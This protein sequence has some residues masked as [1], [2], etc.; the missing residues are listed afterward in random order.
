MTIKSATIYFQVIRVIL[1]FIILLSIAPQNLYAISIPSAPTVTSPGTS[2]SPGSIISEL[3]PILYWN[4]VLGADSY[5]LA[6]S[7]YPYGSSNIIYNPQNV[8]G[9][10]HQVPNGYLSA[11][12]MY[13]WN[14]QARNSAGL[15]IVSNTLYF[16]TQAAAS[17]PAA[18]QTSTY[19]IR[20]MA[21]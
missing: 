3:S 1:F 20:V 6:I 19:R 15:S 14:M 17:V 8:Y 2:T 5:A 9:T 13:R 4:S 10:S 7:K 18:P 21:S 12:V 11:G 16:Q